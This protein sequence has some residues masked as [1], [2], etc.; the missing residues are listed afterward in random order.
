[1]TR[2]SE[3]DTTMYSCPDEVSKCK[4][5]FIFFLLQIV[6]AFWYLLSAERVDTCWQKAC[7]ASQHDKDLIYCGNEDMR[8]Y[9]S[10][11]SNSTNILKEACSPDGDNPP[12]DFGIFNQALS[13]GIVSSTKFVQKYCYCLW[14]GLQNLRYIKLPISVL[15]IF[16]LI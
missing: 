4:S 6:G 15:H 8:G 10:W 12:F 1:M 13:S 7:K 5:I 14:W 16:N 9:D 3:K 2:L 11:I